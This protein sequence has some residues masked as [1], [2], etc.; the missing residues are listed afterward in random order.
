MIK[1]KAKPSEIARRIVTGLIYLSLV[2]VLA[3]AWVQG[4]DISWA[5]KDRI[6]TRLTAEMGHP[7]TIEGPITFNVGWGE[8]RILAE[9]ITTNLGDEESAL[10]ASIFAERAGTSLGLWDLLVGRVAL[11]GLFLREA[12]IA[13]PVP[14]DVGGESADRNPDFIFR[15][16]NQLHR[17]TLDNLTVIR[18]RRDAEPQVV[19]VDSLIVAPEDGGL[20]AA[21]VGDVEGTPYDVDA[22][23]EDLG[24]L[25]RFSGSPIAITASIGRNHV[26]G[27]GTIERIWPFE[28]DLTLTGNAQNVARIAQLM[29]GHLPGAGQGT[30]TGHVVF[31]EGQ[32]FIEFSDLALNHNGANG[33]EPTQA[34][35]PASGSISVL[36]I[37][38][39]RY[40][41]TGNIDA[42][43]VRVDPLLASP[44]GASRRSVAEVIERPLDAG[45]P[46]AERAIPYGALGRISG[47]FTIAAAELRFRDAILTNVSI[48]VAGDEG[49]MQIDGARAIYNDQPLFISIS[50]SS[51]EQTIG[52]EADAHQIALGTLIEELGGNSF[53]HG[54]AL[55]AVRGTG[56]GATVGDVMR[57]LTGQTN[58]MIGRGRLERG[59]I[60]FL[61]GDLL[62]SFFSAATQEATPLVCLINR[63]DFENGVGTS[64]AFLLDTNLITISGQGRINLARN[65]ID[66]RLAPRP[67]DP[68]LLSLAAD[69]KVEGPI[70]GPTI[71]P[72]VGGIVR[73]VATTI[74]SLALTGGAAALLPLL[75]S[76][77]GDDANPC[78]AALVGDDVPPDSATPDGQATP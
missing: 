38:G 33:E 54:P 35:G 40:Q 69:Y 22:H 36:R 58:L 44:D 39:D 65:N 76:G 68:T 14:G 41:I 53:V 46:F 5:V 47:E 57:S 16:L 60:D 50:A 43:Y 31:S 66:F 20:R 2:I 3:L 59:G 15:I 62:R 64:R 77:E 24:G 11:R 18:L 23:L 71:R 21:F 63:T 56:T 12:Q 28:A 32:A 52:I 55:I 25:L 67:K 45:L 49:V 30:F 29:G 48:P 9:D 34:L 51:T 6:E 8:A 61:A 13:L 78:I 74:G 73:G 26:E 42:D 37:E 75:P 7:V 4:R 17:V 19:E 70:M 10:E 27:R 72:E 1:G